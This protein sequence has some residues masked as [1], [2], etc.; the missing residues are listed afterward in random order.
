ME[1]S[2]LRP[3]EQTMEDVAHLMEESDDIIMAHQSWL[4]GCGFRQIG[5]HSG[6]GIA[7]RAVALFITS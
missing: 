7:T 1:T 6:Y 2:I 5:N 3:A 4:I